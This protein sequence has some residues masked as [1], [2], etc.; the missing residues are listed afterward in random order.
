ME[1]LTLPMAHLPS[2]MSSRM[3]FRYSLLSVIPFLHI[4]SEM[5]LNDR[6]PRAELMALNNA[7]RMTSASELPSSPCSCGIVQPPS[8]SA[9]FPAEKRWLSCPRPTLGGRALPAPEIMRVAISRSSGVVTLKFLAE[10]GTIFTFFPSAST[11]AASSVWWA[12]FLSAWE[13]ASLRMP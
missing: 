4:P 7:C 1:T 2:P 6:P 9:F 12:L 8:T 3:A 11:M 10:H 13:K 5:M